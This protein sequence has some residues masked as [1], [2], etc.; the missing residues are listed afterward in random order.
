MRWI[1]FIALLT[2]FLSHPAELFG[3][4]S[5]QVVSDRLALVIGNS[6]YK[7]GPLRNPA[8]DAQ[9]MSETLTKLGFSVTL[10]KDGSLRDMEH[11]VR[12]FARKLR[13]G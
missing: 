5:I 2:F 4:R 3:Q 1:T 13:R 10:I 7:V 6:K 8:N 11:A 9:A 12:A